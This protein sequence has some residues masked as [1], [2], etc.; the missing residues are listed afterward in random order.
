MFREAGMNATTFSLNLSSWDTSKLAYMDNMFYMAGYQANTWS[1][2]I[3]QTN[4]N[5]INNT[6]S[7]MYGETTSIYAQPSGSKSFTL[8]Q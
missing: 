1:V 2:I 8:A 7:R 3:P 6:T 5:G 4:K